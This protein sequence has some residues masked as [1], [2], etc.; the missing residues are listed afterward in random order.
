[1]S[2]P[3]PAITTIVVDDHTLFRDGIR[4]LLSTEPDIE[5]LAEG[6]NG[7]DAIALTSQLEPDVVLL[8]VEMPG[9]PAQEVIPHIRA[10]CPGSRVIVVTMYADPELAYELMTLGARAYLV[11][12]VSR[13]QLFGAIRTVMHDDMRTLLASATANLNGPDRAGLAGKPVLSAREQA[14]LELAAEAM[15]NAQ[16]GSILFIAEGTVRRH[17]SNAYRKLGASGRL[18]AVNRAVAAGLIRP[19]VTRSHDALVRRYFTP[20]GGYARNSGDG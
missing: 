8:D 17:L 18:A 11:K 15:T 19:A 1:V 10:I 2:Q 20:K 9:P 5:V 12:D 16:I 6:R 7:E 4:E 3:A 14:V 13:E